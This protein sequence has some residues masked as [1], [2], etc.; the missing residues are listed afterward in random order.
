MKETF[1][2]RFARFRKQAN[3]TQ[4][5]VGEKLHLS[6]QAISKWENDLSSPDIS[7]LKEISSLFHVS[8]DELCGNESKPMIT[9]MEKSKKSFDDLILH[10]NVLSSDQDKVKINLPMAH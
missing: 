2:Q 5:E 6:A 10:I 9:L 7:M 8:I 4:E 1:G 3:L